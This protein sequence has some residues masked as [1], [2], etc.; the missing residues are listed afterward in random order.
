MR[1]FLYFSIFFLV[2]TLQFSCI[3]DPD[4]SN[5]PEFP[6][7][8]T[9]VVDTLGVTKIS[10]S[11]IES[12]DFIEY[13]IVRSSKDSIPNFSKLSST[14]GSVIIGRVSDAKRTFFFDSNNNN[15]IFIGKVY[16]R[17]FAR[18][19][20]RN[21]SSA[22]YFV[23]S[24]ISQINFSI[25]SIVQD[26]T[27]LERF[28]FTSTNSS[29]IMMYDAEKEKSVVSNLLPF[30]SSS[31]IALS[32]VAGG[33][34]EV[35][36]WSNFN[37]SIYILDGKTLQ[38]KASI[39]FAG[40]N[41]YNLAVS[42][43]GY[44]MVFTSESSTPIKMF[45]LSDRQVV[46]KINN[47]SPNFISTSN[48]VLITKN[49]NKKEFLIHDGSSCSPNLTRLTYSDQ[50]I[51]GSVSSVGNV[52]SNCNVSRMKV[53][54]TGKYILINSNIFDSQLILSQPIK[55]LNSLYFDT[56]FNAA[57]DKI[58]SSRQ[59]NT[60]VSTIT[61]VDETAVTGTTVLRSFQSKISFPKAFIGKDKIYF[62]A[63]VSSSSFSPLS[64]MEKVKL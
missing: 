32:N 4:T 45:R 50:G 22:N 24:N 13:V 36:V 58:Y 38:Q 2:S 35:I 27:T 44:M 57:E 53:S 39:D 47:G 15:P 5:F 3:K 42:N 8:I 11:K 64:A 49:G 12:S 41:V 30:S 7:T 25:S 43:D 52:S 26:E 29:Q 51:L 1:Y 17:V 46:S 19:T 37:S 48:S 59:T 55:I 20:N 54:V 62:F 6:I 28:Y 16:Y 10:W 21:I 9:S 40:A 18:L 31:R 33:E 61:T 14:D 63:N 60:S 23:N 56:Q 34:P